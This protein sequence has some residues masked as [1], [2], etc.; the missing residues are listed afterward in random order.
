MNQ[1]SS[2]TLI[3]LGLIAFISVALIMPAHPHHTRGKVKAAKLKSRLKQIG[4]TVAMYYADGDSKKFPQSPALFDIDQSLTYTDKTNTWQEMNLNSPYFFFHNQS[5]EYKGSANV[6][7]AT[8]WEPVLINKKEHYYAV[9]FEDGHVEFRNKE[10]HSKLI[11]SNLYR[12]IH[13]FVYHITF[14]N[15]QAL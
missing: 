1:D 2:W 4:T 15:N 12:Q 7:L 6:P 11:T 13:Y 14:Q 5:H 8:N 9:V 3:L 10:E